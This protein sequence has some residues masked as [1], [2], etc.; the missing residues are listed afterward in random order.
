M[1]TYRYTLS[2][3]QAVKEADLAIDGLTVLAGENGSGKSTLSRWLY[4]LVNGVQRFDTFTIREY[5]DKVERLIRQHSMAAREI[6]HYIQ[7]DDQ[8]LNMVR[9]NPVR[10]NSSTA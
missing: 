3:Y 5:V 7:T 1:S 9:A 10:I 4:Y 6:R 2:E 8:S